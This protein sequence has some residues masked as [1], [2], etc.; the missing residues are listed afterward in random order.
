YSLCALDKATGALLAETQCA[1]EPKLVEKFI[2]GLA[3]E[4]DP[5]TKFVTGY[6][7][8]ILGYSLYRSLKN[9]GIDCIILAPTTMYS[10]AKN[11]MVKN[12]SM[13]ARMIAKNLAAN[14]YCA[15][16]VPDEADNEV[17]E[18]IRLRKMMKKDL[19]RVKQQIG[20]F[21]LRQGLKCSA[22]KW[23]L[24]YMD[25][26]K[27]VP[28]SPVLRSVLD[29]MTLQ[30]SELEEK[31][32]RYDQTIETFANSER[33]TKPI[34]ALTSMKGFKTTTAMTIHIEIADFKRFK[35]A[36]AF[37]SYVGLNPSEHSSGDHT[38]KGGISKQ[39]NSIVRT[40][41]IEATQGLVKGS[42]GY[43]SRALKARQAGQE[44]AVISYA[45]KAGAHLHRKFTRM[46]TQ[47]KSYNVAIA[48]V[49]RELAGFI[50]GMETGN[51]NY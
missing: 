51:I 42:I 2:N 5:D 13:D 11:K 6:E 40:T 21:L 10:S 23:T 16:Y 22:S 48:A 39:G 37:M 31:I 36:K 20:M 27:K 7:A 49:A 33:Y 43:K 46:L 14:T 47:G 15:V 32:A 24:A 17:K 29:E 4:L 26:L 18:F 8:G 19:I 38:I 35:T 41:I 12:D 3:E 44:S 50:W 34:H 1:S 9:L 45:D 30:K 25:W 28:L